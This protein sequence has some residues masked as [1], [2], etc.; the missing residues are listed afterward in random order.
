MISRR[1][2]ETP[3]LLD[4]LNTSSIS[5]SNFNVSLP[6]KIIIHGFGSSCKKIWPREMRLSFLLVEDCNVVCVDWEAGAV[7]PNYVRAAVNTRLVGKQVSEKIM[8][9]ILILNYLTVCTIQHSGSIQTSNIFIWNFANSL[10]CMN[11]AY[12]SEKF[13]TSFTVKKP[14][15]HP[16][17]GLLV[18]T[19][20]FVCKW[21]PLMWIILW[22]YL[23][24]TLCFWWGAEERTDH[25]GCLLQSRSSAVG[26]VKDE[27]KNFLD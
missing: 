16:F 27:H 22:T 20:D 25:Q 6:S 18:F 4:Y 7:D 17:P 15:F 19:F 9:L 3:Q 11:D 24:T 1:N 13:G 2:D 12:N 21:F 26:G 14:H 5:T 23:C 10:L 8:T